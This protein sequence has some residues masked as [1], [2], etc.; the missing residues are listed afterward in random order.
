MVLING[1][2]ICEWV[3]IPNHS[4]PPFSPNDLTKNALFPFPIPIF[5]H[6]KHISSFL[7]S[8]FQFFSLTFSLFRFDRRKNV[9]CI[10]QFTP[11]IP[12][13]FFF[14]LFSF[15]NGEVI[16]ALIFFF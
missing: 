2:E 16:C 15:F 14:F 3:L 1:K 4:T 5:R 8:S 11:T 9:G 7:S 6:A 10:T 12:A 13:F